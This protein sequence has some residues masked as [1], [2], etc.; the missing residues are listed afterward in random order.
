MASEDL[1]CKHCNDKMRGIRSY[2]ARTHCIEPECQREY[3]LDEAW[4]SFTKSED[5]E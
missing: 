2:K 3:E 4:K 5:T 1:E